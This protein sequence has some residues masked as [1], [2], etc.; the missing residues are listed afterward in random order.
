MHI[1]FIDPVS[2]KIVL[3]VDMI[4]KPINNCEKWIQQNMA[5]HKHSSRASNPFPTDYDPD[6][7]TTVELDEEQ[8]TYY[9]FQIGILHWIVELGRI[10]IAT[11]VS[12]L[13]SHVTLPRKGTATDSISYICLHEEKTQ[14]LIGIGS[15]LP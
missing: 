15:I 13:A 9:Q 6:L 5:E 11:E 10:D 3:D 12:Q 7:D 2:H 8:A 14:F 1:I 4:N